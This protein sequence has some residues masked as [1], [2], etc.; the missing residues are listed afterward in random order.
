MSISP[1]KKLCTLDR[2]LAVRADAASRGQV[3]IHCHGCFDIVHPGHIQYLQYARSLGDVLIVTVTADSLVNKGVDR[4][5]IP[6][7]LRAASLAALECVDFVYVNPNPTAVEL[8]DA[9]RPDVYVKGKEYERNFDP[10]FLA[11]R[12]A[13]ERHGGRVVFSSGDIVYS[14]TALI[15]TIS[16]GT[17]NDE[18]LGRFRDRYDLSAGSIQ[19]LLARFRGQ[20]IVVV[21]DYILDRY[22]FCDATGV[23]GEAP[24]MALRHLTSKEFDGGAAVIALHLAG[25]GADASIV[26]S[27][28]DDE[29]SRQAELRLRSQGIGVHATRHRRRAVAKNRYLVD[30]SKLF[31]VD[32]GEIAPADS[33]TEQ[34][35]VD[36]LLTAADGAAAVVF[37]DFGYGVISP[38]LLDRVMAP[39]REMVPV[40][41]ADVSGRQ[42]SLLNFRN[43]DLLCPTEREVRDTLHDFSSGLGALVWNLLEATGAK[44]A[45]ITLGK[46]G[47]VTFDHPDDRSLHQL[48]KERGRLRSEYLPSLAAHAIDPLGCGDALLAA[49][50]LTLAAGGTLQQAAFLGSAAAAF[51]VQQVGNQPLSTDSLAQTLRLA[52]LG[53]AP[54]AARLAS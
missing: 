22:H 6:D 15:G 23:A 40:I 33:R 28:A 7:D 39:L 9:L 24:V 54:A 25:L 49:A 13:V 45:M 44:Q 18:K 34:S 1:S 41:T 27:L 8:L 43:V 10:R 26:T 11:E 5:L 31:K 36:M 46:Q 42:A 12:Q 19:R 2:L 30:Q 16:P 20:K 47:L 50:S 14:S 48:G 53:S 17:F 37:A 3:V 4:P 21:G 51:E 38:G 52:D 35:L 32:Q 29:P